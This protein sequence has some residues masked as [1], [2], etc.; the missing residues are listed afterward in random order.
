[1]TKRGLLLIIAVLGVGGLVV[2]VFHGPLVKGKATVQLNAS[3]KATVYIDGREAGTTP[4]ENNTLKAGEIDFRLIPEASFSASWQRKLTLAPKTKSVVNWEFDPNPDNEAG[5][6][7]YFEKTSLRDKAGLI[8]TS[9]PDNCS[10]SVDGQMRGFSP[11]NLEDIG[12]GSHKIFISL[13]GY[14]AR[15]VMARAINNYRLVLEVKFAKEVVSTGSAVAVESEV[16]DEKPTIDKPYVLIKDTPTGWLRVRME[17]STAAT[18]AAKV[19]PGEKYALLDEKS[20]WYKIKYEQEKEGW[21]SGR[22]AEKFD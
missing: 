17:P 8:V 3:P 18:E 1:M 9:E 22:Y 12:E 19:D 4:Y 14:K 7:L 11:L 16:A 5:A 2:F 21:I 20:G 15:E 6:I 10:V 13:P